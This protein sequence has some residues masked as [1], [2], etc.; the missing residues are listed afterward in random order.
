MRNSAVV[1][2]AAMAS[3]CGGGDDRS[4]AL[5][6]LNG[7]G[8][9]TTVNAMATVIVELNGTD[10]WADPAMDPKQPP[11][12]RIPQRYLPAHMSGSGQDKIIVRSIDLR[13][14]VEDIDLP[15]TDSSERAFA[16]V[17][18]SEAA[19]GWAQRTGMSIQAAVRSHG[20]VKDESTGLY[21]VLVDDSPGYSVRYRYFRPDASADL[22]YVHLDCVFYESD[23]RRDACLIQLMPRQNVVMSLHFDA[24]GIADWRIWGDGMR[25][26]AQGW[27]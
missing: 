17:S 7:H 10:D 4:V 9:A 3:A 25:K 2:L 18:L 8:S 22:E 15:A 1:W 6:G 11:L 19:D 14:P 20:S 24:A 16:T 21:R 12:L 26:L 27:N 5:A 13:I 23:K